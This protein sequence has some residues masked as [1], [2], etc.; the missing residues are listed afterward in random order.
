LWRSVSKEYYFALGNISGFCCCF[1]APDREKKKKKK[2]KGAFV[3]AVCLW[4][5]KKCFRVGLK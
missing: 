2:K 4:G 5:G 3:S 1:K